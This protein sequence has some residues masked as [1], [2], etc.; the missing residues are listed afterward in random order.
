LSD[1]S[2]PVPSGQNREEKNHNKAFPDDWLD[3]L[4][5]ASFTLSH[6]QTHFEAKK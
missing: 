1:G 2:T 4:F 6:D 3:I 5:N